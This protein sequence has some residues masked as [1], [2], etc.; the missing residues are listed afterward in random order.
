V[1]GWSAGE[2][3]LF[4]AVEA[5]GD[6]DPAVGHESRLDGDDAV[7]AVGVGDAHCGGASVV[8]DG[9]DRHGD[10]VVA[11]GVDEGDGGLG[12]AA[13]CAGARVAGAERDGTPASSA[14]VMNAGRR[15]WGPTR[16]AI[17]ARRAI[18]RTIRPAA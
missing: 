11:A 12:A 4:A 7:G 6:L 1:W 9:G 8:D 17:P 16:L 5:G 10:R 2:A 18:R 14:A 15:V 13:P 3:D